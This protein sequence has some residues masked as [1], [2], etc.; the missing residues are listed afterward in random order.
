MSIYY[1]ARQAYNTSNQVTNNFESVYVDITY[2]CVQHIQRHSE[3]HF[4]KCVF[5]I[6]TYIMG[7][8]VYDITKVKRRLK[9]HL[10]TLEY[11]VATCKMDPSSL[12]I[13]WEHVGKNNYQYCRR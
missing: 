13:S 11:K 5:A 9:K 10:R 12:L 2:M 7:H 1:T 4:N 3:F 8:P 6:P